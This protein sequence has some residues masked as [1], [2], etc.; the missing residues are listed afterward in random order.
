MLK[1][2]KI[3]S[4]I[5]L[6]LKKKYALWIYFYFIFT[7]LVVNYWTIKNNFLL[8][9]VL[10][11]IVCNVPMFYFYQTFYWKLL[12]KNS[13]S[14]KRMWSFSVIYTKIQNFE[15]LWMRYVRN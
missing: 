14:Q 13:Y 1:Y 2:I 6:K 4:L 12:Q 3:F 10:Y 15:D 8:C 11:E 5:Y 9:C 7:F